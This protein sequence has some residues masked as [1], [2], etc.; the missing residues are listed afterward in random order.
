MTTPLHV[1]KLTLCNNL[2]REP[3]HFNKLCSKRFFSLLRKNGL[4]TIGN[5]V[6]H[7]YQQKRCIHATAPTS[8]P[9][10][11]PYEVLGVKKTASASE[12]KKA[13]YGLAKKY[14][15]DTNKDKDARE[16]FVQIQ[17][18]YEILSD[19]QKRQQ[20]DQFG[21]GF[22]PS[23]GMG[24]AGGN[25]YGGFGGGSNGF[26][27]GFDPN[28]IFNQFFG[29]GFGGAA[30]GS[31]AGGNPFHPSQGED[32]QVPLT[33]SFMEAVKGAT[34]FVQINKVT[35]CSSCRGTG[36]GAGKKR[37]T[38]GVCHGTGVQTISM[39][40]FHMQTTC[41]SCGGVGSSIPP[42]AGC[43]TCNSMGK[44]KER[45]TVQVKV[46]PGVDHNSRI[47]ISGEGDAPI[48]GQGPNGD[49]FVVLNVQASNI[50]RRQDADIFVDARVPFY[51]AMLGG[52]VRIPTIDG[53]VDV[54]IPSGAQPGDNI[55]LRGRGIQKLHSHVRGDQIVTLKVEFPRSLRGR[56]KEIIQEYAALV[57]EEYRPKQE[58]KPIV[59][60]PDTPP[61]S[62]KTTNHATTAKDSS[63]TDRTQNDNNNSSKKRTDNSSKKDGGFFKN[64]FGKIKEKICNEDE[65][66]SDKG[67]RK[68]AD[69]DTTASNKKE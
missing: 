46:P 31:A 48:E 7:K 62:P 35:N 37:A 33:L 66:E 45:K 34:K 20:Y 69:D 38:C 47:R 58:Q 65:N 13:Y 36:L 39:G 67:N 27:G 26:P 54:K 22:D 8:A 25:P 29:G 21:H 60:Q 18:A 40:G 43:H 61:P 32:I 10:R 63:T 9:K 56:Q 52:R 3:Y 17:E 50:F 30:A 6:H 15:P 19:D 51:K 64:A 41:R 49:L 24:G 4:K 23:G 42:G 44:V 55:A 68:A 11:D 12:I 2:K 16:K 59:K 1:I 57:D 14:H 28:D 5:T 53:D